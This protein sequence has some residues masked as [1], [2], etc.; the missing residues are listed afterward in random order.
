VKPQDIRR[1]YDAS[2]ALDYETTFL[3]SDLNAP[4]TAYELELLQTLLTSAAS[5]LDVACGTGYFLRR[6]PHVKRVGIDLSPAMLEIARASTPGAEFIEQNYLDERAEW[7]GAFDLVSCMWY[8]YCMVE[9]IADLRRLI[10]NLATWTNPAGTC[11][12]PLADPVLITGFPLQHRLERGGNAGEVT[13][14]GILW[15]Y[16]ENEGTK[17]HSNML[18]PL[19]ECMIEFFELHFEDVTLV[20]YPPRFAGWTG[21]PAIIARKKRPVAS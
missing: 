4:D 18:A 3:T 8:A 9:S 13:L 5:W 19:V 1:L 14:T 17:V 11:F 16:H 7:T 6:F 12:M 21:R 10:Q 15:G 20:R 2:Y